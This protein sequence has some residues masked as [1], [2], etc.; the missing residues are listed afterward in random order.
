MVAP[1]CINCGRRRGK[2]HLTESHFLNKLTE[3]ISI[4]SGSWADTSWSQSPDLSDISSLFSPLQSISA[5]LLLS[6]FG[7]RQMEQLGRLFGIAREGQKGPCHC[8]W[9]AMEQARWDSGRWDSNQGL[10]K[11]I[12]CNRKRLRI[13][14][15]SVLAAN[16]L[17]REG[18]QISCHAAAPGIPPTSAVGYRNFHRANSRMFTVPRESDS[19]QK[20]LRQL[21][22]R[23]SQGS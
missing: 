21:T 6:G 22:E 11:C 2:S 3:A 19:P 14:A 16:I 20:F 12:T 17:L 18:K 13:L 5:C 9:Q 23:P 4:T 8:R 10:G 15:A 7:H 1:Y